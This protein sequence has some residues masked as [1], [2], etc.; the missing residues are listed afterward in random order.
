[1]YRNLH[2]DYYRKQNTAIVQRNE[3]K[4]GHR[5]LIVA[6]NFASIL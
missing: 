4:F 6:T 3:Q 5:T 1:M 2:L